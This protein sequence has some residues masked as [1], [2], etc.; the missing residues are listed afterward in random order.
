MKNIL[1]CPLNWGRGHATRV[2]HIAQL[3]HQDGHNVIVAA[4][5]ELLDIFDDSVCSG[6]LPFRSI[7]I[8]YSSFLP[9]CLA[10]FIQSPLLLIQFLSDRYR[11]AR[12]VKKYKTDIVISDNRFGAWTGRAWS[13]Y[14]THQLTIKVPGPTKLLAGL[15]S[16]LHRYIARQYDE[17]WIPDIKDG[18]AG[19]LT[20]HPGMDNTRYIGI[21]SMLKTCEAQEPVGLKA[22]DYYAVII[23]GPEPQ[24][25]VLE[26]LLINKFSDDD[27]AYLIA[28]GRGSDG[29]MEYGGD[30]VME[31]G[32]DG[33][34]IMYYSNLGPG[35][36]KYILASSKGVICRG[37]YST[38]MDLAVMG[39][40]ALVIP[41][42]GQT[43]QEYLADYLDKKGWIVACKQSEISD[44]DLKHIPHPSGFDDLN[45]KSEV[46]LR[47]AL[48]AL[49]RR[50]SSQKKQ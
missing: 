23:S 35:E 34:N 13:V 31:Y 3:L 42:P 7:R 4:S 20:L 45:I 44:I 6:T 50:S 39:R 14:I 47:E 37:G 17:C 1:I 25:S 15:I 5:E 26:K 22:K 11:I 24:R 8:R 46:L 9:L 19:E 2:R 28:G 48:D 21:L 30:G 10:I 38:L 27:N 43:E 16:G 18:L 41:T 32:G 40:G 49:I 33:V 12:L 29:V 36:I